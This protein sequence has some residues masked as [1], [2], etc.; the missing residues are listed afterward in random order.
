MNPHTA[1]AEKLQTVLRAQLA[2]I[3][4]IAAIIS[5]IVLQ[6]LRGPMRRCQ[7]A[8]APLLH[9]LRTSSVLPALA[10]IGRSE[11]VGLREGERRPVRTMPMFFAD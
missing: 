2:V 7:V 5:P 4:T 3:A 8:W 11:A 10:A 6:L 1:S 9:R